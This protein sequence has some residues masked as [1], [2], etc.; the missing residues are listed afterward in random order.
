MQMV[1]GLDRA[2]ERSERRFTLLFVPVA[3]GF[4]AR[5]ALLVFDGP[6]ARKF[7]D[8]GYLI[9]LL[10][11]IG[12]LLS[13]FANPF[14][15]RLSDRTATRFGRRVPYALLGVSMSS[16]VF[17]LIPLAP[18]F[19]VLLAL[20]AL[21]ALCV[22][23][24]S[25]PLMSLVPDMVASERRGRAMALLMLAGGLG[26]IGIQAAGKIFWETSFALVYYATGLA[27]LLFAVPP[28]FFIREPP[29]AE[30]PPAAQSAVSFAAVADALKQR[31]PILLFLTSAALRYLGAGMLIRYLTLFA[32]IDLGVSVGNASLAIAVAGLIR[33]GLAL[34]AGRLA[35]RYDRKRL[36]MF[37]SFAA[38]GIHLVTGW[39][40][41][42]FWQLFFVIGLGT[43]AGVVEMTAG[44]P[45][46]MD[47]LP[48]HRRAELISVNI[49]LTN[50]F[51]A[52]GALLGGAVFASTSG[53]RGIF[54][55]AALCFA[56]SA[57]ILSRLK[58]P[59]GGGPS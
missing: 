51:Q 7:T 49:V 30:S 12:P 55:V 11:A 6:L 53:Y 2:F 57:L 36:L 37:A 15:G 27:S 9:G 56:A 50:L 4:G 14:F 33:L 13:T 17:F 32:A 38:A 19:A 18:S 5:M 46:F 42:E 40:V 21:R 10:L 24:G 31:G 45:L 3:F 8:D 22:S 28:L 47:L 25:G 23:V 20:F 48:A 26:A 58:T 35:D 44:G 29:P 52:G 39:W 54:P 59:A 16:F 41:H 43:V 34:P 1:G